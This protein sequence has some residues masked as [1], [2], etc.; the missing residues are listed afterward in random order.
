M[1]EIGKTINSKDMDSKS[2]KME[3]ST[4]ATISQARNKAKERSFGETIAHTKGNLRKTIFMAMEN[5]FGKME[6][7]MRENGIII[8]CMEK[9]CLFGPMAEDTKVA[10]KTI[11]NMVLASLLLRMGGFTKDN[12]RMGNSMGEE[13]IK[14]RK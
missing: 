6:E 14:R 7:C 10:T 11:K 4:K 8:R 1:L 13:D 2:G 9:D 5:M 3:H 12:G